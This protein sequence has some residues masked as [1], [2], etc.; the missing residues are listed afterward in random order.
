VDEAG[1]ARVDAAGEEGHAQGF[2]VRDAL[3]GADDVGAF[4][5]LWEGN[6]SMAEGEMGKV[7]SDKLGNLPCFREST[8]RATRRGLRLLRTD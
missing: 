6:V 8:C 4:E 5:V 1:A 7:E 2:V 3:Q